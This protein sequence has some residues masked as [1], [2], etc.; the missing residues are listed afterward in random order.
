MRV[1]RTELS[2]DGSFLR[3]ADAD[4]KDVSDFLQ[5]LQQGQSAQQQVLHLADR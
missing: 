2:S 5:G 1:P 4:L 3:V